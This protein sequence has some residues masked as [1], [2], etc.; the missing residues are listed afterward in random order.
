MI[1]LTQVKTPH[2]AQTIAQ[3]DLIN[4]PGPVTDALRRVLFSKQSLDSAARHYRV[5]SGDIVFY[6]EVNERIH[7]QNLDYAGLA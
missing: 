4:A 5:T 6:M 3:F 1:N 7:C 2:Q